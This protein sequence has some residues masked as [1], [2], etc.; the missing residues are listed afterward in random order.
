MKRFIYNHV[1]L[2]NM[3]I[4]SRISRGSKMDQIYIPKN[5]HGF[6][7]GSYVIIKPLEENVI[8]EK[9]Y[10][11]NVNHIEPIKLETINEIIKVIDK[12]CNYDN[13]IFTGSFVDNGFKFN[14]IDIL[15]ISQN[16]LDVEHVKDAIENK[17]GIKI[18]IIQLTN[19]DL[20]KGLSTDPLYQMMLSKCISKKRFIYNVKNEINYKV[21]DLHLLKSKAM[22]DNFGILNGSEKYY[23]TRNLISLFLYADGKKVSKETVDAEIKK[24]FNISVEKIKDNMVGNSFLRKYKEI[25]NK[26]FSKIVKS[27]KNDP[28]Q[29]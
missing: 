5:R 19:Q 24:I 21:L 26:A 22:N 23:L 9:P 10:F 18:H 20:M 27:V 15:L 2:R 7:I 17:T 3:E 16:K 25:Y 4:V 6:N 12:N 28:K 1:I 14:D 29:E 11:Y 8:A 13:V